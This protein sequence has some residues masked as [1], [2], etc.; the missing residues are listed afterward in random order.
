MSGRS[1]VAAL[2][3]VALST[4]PAAAA[5]AACNIQKVAELPVSM[6]GP[7]ARLTFKVNG[8]PTQFMADSG[9]FYSFINEAA[10][11]RMKLP[12]SMAPPGFAVSGFGGRDSHVSVATVKDFGIA[13]TVIHNVQFL[14]LRGLDPDVA[15]VIGQNILSAFD[16]EY[17][18]GDGVIRLMKPTSGCAH[19]NLAYW[20]AGKPIGLMDIERVEP[21]NPMIRGE[22][23]VNGQAV[24]VMFDSGTPTSMLK[25]GAAERVGFNPSGAGVRPGGSV[26]G[27]GRRVVDSWI[28]PFDSI[29]I[30]GEQ[31]RNTQL[32]VADF[33][34][35][36]QDMVLGMDFFLSHRIYVSHGQHLLYFT[37]NG[38]PVFRLDRLTPAQLQASAGPAPALAQP[39]ADAAA[40]T[41]AD[42]FAR[43]GQA[44][45]SRREYAAALADFNRA[46]ELDPK[47]SLHFR[48]RAVA[49]LALRQPVLAM[50]DFDEALKLQPDDVIARLG[51]GELYLRAQSYDR[52]AT[53]FGAAIKIEPDRALQVAG[54]YTGAGQFE[55]AT[56]AYDGWIAANPRHA[57]LSAALSGRCWTRALWNHELDKALADCEAAL[58]GGPRVAAVLDSR[59]L[60]HLRRSE[61]D[62][63]IADYDA[64][65]R[66]QPKQAWSL[67]GRGLAKLAKGDKAGEADL[68]AATAVAPNLPAMAKQYGLAP[69][70]TAAAAPAAVKA[71]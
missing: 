47:A 49:H 55:R 29:D 32:R 10:A 23:K 42:G 48:N 1:L 51:R 58:K 16:T 4:A 46:A 54:V 63:A 26:Y 60:V 9:A 19:A 20:S 25:L 33:V 22:A 38:G 36:K 14:V 43:R 2:A 28:A 3:L 15:G 44:F 56:T 8:Q 37:Y 71:Q 52:A 40:P 5:P 68:A 13:D 61:F 24:G 31:I 35:E 39:S 21:S 18:L 66:L 53:D 62:L 65:I 45:M 12:T 50:A 11:A 7:R 69:P 6:V 57:R 64:A 34:S 70:A 30:G 59:G 41:D 67:Y 17:D 27:I